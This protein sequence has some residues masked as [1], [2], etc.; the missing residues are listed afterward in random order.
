MRRLVKHV[1]AVF[2]HHST[3]ALLARRYFEPLNPDL[4]YMNVGHSETSDEQHML[5]LALGT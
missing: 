2:S 5:F 4:T 3:T 1:Y